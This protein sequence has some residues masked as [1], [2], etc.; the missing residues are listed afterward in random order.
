VPRSLEGGAFVGEMVDAVD[1]TGG[2]IDPAGVVACAM[3]TGAELVAA[4][5]GSDTESGSLQATR[6]TAAT[7]SSNVSARANWRVSVFCD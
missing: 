2:K 3:P 6:L 7:I 4:G 5:V 1:E